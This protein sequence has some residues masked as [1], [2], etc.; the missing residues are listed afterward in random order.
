MISTTESPFLNTFITCLCKF[1]QNWSQLTLFFIFSLRKSKMCHVVVVA[2]SKSLRVDDTG[3]DQL[4]GCV[5]LPVLFVL[6]GVYGRLIIS[7][8]GVDVGSTSVHFLP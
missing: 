5:D 6:L 4:F 2:P 7:P 8:E 3:P 1:S